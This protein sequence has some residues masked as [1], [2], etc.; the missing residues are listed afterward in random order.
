MLVNDTK[1][2]NNNNNNN[3]HH[4]NNNKSTKGCW[5]F[6]GSADVNLSIKRSVMVLWP[7]YVFISVSIKLRS[8][9]QSSHAI[10]IINIALFS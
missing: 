2:K 1:T 5:K 6:V 4:N 8:V 9:H 10:N 7:R 3:H